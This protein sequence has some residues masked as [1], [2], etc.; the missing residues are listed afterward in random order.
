MR[1]KEKEITDR[2]EIEEI[3][4]HNIIC[5]IALSDN[6]VPYII[7]MNY[8]YRKN[9]IYLH[10]AGVGKKIEIIQK[11]NNVCFEITDSIEITGARTACDYGTK[12]RSVIGFGRIKI[13]DSAR[14][15]KEALN[16]IMNKHTKKA[17]WIISDLMVLKVTVLEIEIESVSGKKSGYS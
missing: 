11:N 4:T 17:D 5:R 13:M 1:R 7:P 15:K 8:G 3:L 2:N 16:I 9:K 12:Y 10:S 6:N 14:D